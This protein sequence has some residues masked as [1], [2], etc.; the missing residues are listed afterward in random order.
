MQAEL[1]TWNIGRCIGWYYQVEWYKTLPGSR[2]IFSM[3]KTIMLVAAPLL[4]NDL[5]TKKI[6]LM[7]SSRAAENVTSRLHTLVSHFRKCIP[8]GCLK[9]KPAK[10]NTSQRWSCAWIQN[11]ACLTMRSNA[12]K[13]STALGAVRHRTV[14]E[15][16]KWLTGRRTKNYVTVP[17]RMVERNGIR[18]ATL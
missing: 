2:W 8:C 11:A 13:C 14:P 10:S 18:H 12:V 9:K 17:D 4:R 3:E 5:W 6:E 7:Q 16:A 15:N 1:P